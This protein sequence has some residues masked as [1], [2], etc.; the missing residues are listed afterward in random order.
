MG[1]E[2]QFAI[3][4]NEKDRTKPHV[5]HG[6]H[7]HLR[8]RTPRSLECGRLR[9]SIRSFA[10]WSHRRVLYCT[11][12]TVLT[13]VPSLSKF[14]PKVREPLRPAGWLAASQ[15]RYTSCYRLAY[16]SCFRTKRGQRHPV[17]LQ[18]QMAFC[19]AQA[20]PSYSGLRVLP[21]RLRSTWWLEHD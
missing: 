19:G 9:A 18:H 10:C 13:V 17:L 1:D 15:D 12:R 21:L 16:S 3:S 7:A 5:S 8:K 20:S 14:R 6:R 11:V 2:A 4:F